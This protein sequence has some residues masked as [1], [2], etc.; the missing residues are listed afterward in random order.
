MTRARP[1]LILGIATAALPFLVGLTPVTAEAAALGC[2]RRDGWQ[3]WYASPSK[4]NAPG[5]WACGW[6]KS[7]SYEIEGKVWDTLPDDGKPA[8][9][10]IRLANGTTVTKTG[11]AAGAAFPAVANPVYGSPPTIQECN[12]T[13]CGSAIRVDYL[14]ER[15][16]KAGVFRVMTYNIHHGI[17]DINAE[18][19]GGK[20]ATIPPNSMAK[21]ASTIRRNDPDILVVNEANR[22]T[23]DQPQKLAQALGMNYTYWND[24]EGVDAGKDAGNAILSKYPV[25]NA[26]R[27]VLPYDAGRAPRVLISAE[28]NVTGTLWVPVYTTHL[29]PGRT[30]AE[31]ATR[32]AQIAKVV[33]R[34]S[35][36]NHRPGAAPTILAGDMNSDPARDPGELAP[37]TGMGFN[38]AWRLR[39]GVTGYTHSSSGPYQRIDRIFTSPQ[40]KNPCEGAAVPESLSSDH[41]PVI[42]D[43]YFITPPANACIG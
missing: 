28:V 15:D 38:D 20:C 8:K 39:P 17:T 16:K 33:A 18:W 29:A 9:L 32:K 19:P 2:A 3:R 4:A 31:R 24:W 43:S 14:P 27:F 42:A 21:V 5:V 25:R 7:R 13:A 36:R 41:L 26:D 37:I 10:I 6:Y 12:A 30:D 34:I 40:L 35:E 23:E 11:T 1:F 22:C